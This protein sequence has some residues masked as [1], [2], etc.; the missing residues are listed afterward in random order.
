MFTDDN[1]VYGDQNVQVPAHLNFGKFILDRL[2]LQK[3]EIALVSTNFYN[4]KAFKSLISTTFNS[5][6]VS[7]PTFI[8]SINSYKFSSRL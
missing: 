5:T 7:T 6:F 4:K 3:D 1:Y 8:R 2:R